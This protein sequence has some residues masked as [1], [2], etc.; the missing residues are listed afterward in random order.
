MI[1]SVSE[2]VVCVVSCRASKGAV[3]ELLKVC[4]KYT[5]FPF[6]KYV[7]LSQ[8]NCSCDAFRITLDPGGFLLN[9]KELSFLHFF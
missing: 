7:L 6:V 9:E 3:G 4:D 5:V 8:E 1:C 2:N